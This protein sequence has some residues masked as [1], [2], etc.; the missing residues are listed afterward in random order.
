MIQLKSLLKVIDNSG[1]LLVECINVLGSK[2]VATLGDEIV[3]AVKKVR[4]PGTQSNAHQSA[5]SSAK[6]KKGDVR[7]AVVVRCRAPVQRPDGSTIR[8][9]DNACVVTNKDGQPV[10]NRVLGVIANEC[11]S[12]KWAKIVSLAPKV[13]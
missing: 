1:A 13:I 12:Q 7:R 10:G 11:R 5:S 6:L 2:K 3:I 4:P 8:F 9:D